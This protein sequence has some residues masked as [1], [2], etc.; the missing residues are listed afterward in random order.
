MF[1]FHTQPLYEVD[2]RLAGPQPFW[3]LQRKRKYL[4]E[5]GIEP[6]LSEVQPVVSR[7]TGRRLD[8]SDVNTVIILR[9]L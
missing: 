9:F 3:K 7:Y 8:S 2:R 4:P 1:K 6:R 5:L